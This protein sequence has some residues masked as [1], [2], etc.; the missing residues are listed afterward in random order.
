MTTGKG[1]GLL[2]E[3]G[4]GKTLTAISVAGIL[5]RQG[6]IRRVLVVCPTSIT[7]VWAK[8]I[9]D[10]ATYPCQVAVLQGDKKKRLAALDELNCMVVPALKWAVINYESTHRDGIFTA[11]HDYAA[12]LIICDESQR[13]ANHAAAQSK[14]LHKLGDQAKYKLILSGTPIKGKA[15]DI[16]SQFRFCD[17]HVF[18]ANFY[19]FRS[20]YCV[21]GGYQNHQIVAYRNLDELTRRM[22]SISVRATKAEALDLPDQIF[23]DRVVRLTAKERQIYD[24]VRRD[25]FAELENGDRLTAATVLTK[26][27]RLQQI[28]GGFMQPDESDKPISTGTA[29]LDALADIVDDYVLQTGEKLVVFARFRTELDAI[30]KLLEKRGLQYGLISGEVPQSER[31]GIVQDFQTNPETKVFVAQIATAGL[32]ITLTAASLTVFYSMGYS[33][34]E[35]EQATARTHRIGQQQKC[36]YIHLVAE[37]TVDEQV[38]KALK[39]KEEL[40]ASIMDNWREVL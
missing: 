5:Y 8:D 3:M 2:F 23:E 15:I 9:A 4:C 36:T 40:A 18:G 10:F 24:R 34:A 26:L 27:L 35:Y 14:A 31:G 12:D 19:A 38:M 20:R 32:G 6:L 33:Y 28:T 30:C 7:A 29:K 13:I 1:F 21:L 16:Y 39:A 37:N 17:P 22:S 25:S 11:L